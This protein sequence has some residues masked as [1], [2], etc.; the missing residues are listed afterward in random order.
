MSRSQFTVLDELSAR[1]S[2][3]APARAAR[4]PAVEAAAADAVKALASAR[5]MARLAIAERRT[6]LVDD[7]ARRRRLAAVAHR[8]CRPTSA[9]RGGLERA[10]ASLGDALGLMPGETEATLL[11]AVSGEALMPTRPNGLLSRTRSSMS[12]S[13][14]SAEQRHRSPILRQAANDPA[15]ADALYPSRSS[16]P[17]GGE[18]HASDWSSPKR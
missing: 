10:M 9:A 6:R 3:A 2:C 11:A 8:R 15:R 17:A 13:G 4:G 14:Q 16:S 18:I 7:A 12:S 1:R 5:P